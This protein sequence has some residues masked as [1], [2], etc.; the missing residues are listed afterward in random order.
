MA[1][2]PRAAMMYREKRRKY[3]VRVRNRCAV[4]GRARG[5]MRKFGVSR[6]V[7]REMALRGEIPGVRKAS[8]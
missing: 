4:S 1:K 2:M 7:F 6:I 3:K 5:Y 8:W